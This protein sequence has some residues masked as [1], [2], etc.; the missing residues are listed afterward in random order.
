MDHDQGAHERQPGF[1]TS[2]Y[3]LG[4]LVIGPGRSLFPAD[5]APGAWGGCRP[6]TRGWTCCPMTPGSCGQP[7][8]ARR[9]IRALTYCSIASYIRLASG[10]ILLSSAWNVL[11]HA[12]R[13]PSN[14][15]AP[16]AFA[17]VIYLL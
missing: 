7:C 3:A 13:E 12:Q 9:G 14:R 8:S 17:S 6:S 4:L 11:Y 1:W 2:R 15:T 5:R 16:P 10:F